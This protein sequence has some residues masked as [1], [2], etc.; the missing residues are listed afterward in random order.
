MERLE[1]ARSFDP[2]AD[3]ADP[4]RVDG[5]V[6]RVPATTGQRYF[7]LIRGVELVTDEHEAHVL[8][9]SDLTARGIGA[10]LAIN[11]GAVDDTFST[12]LAEQAHV[13]AHR[14]NDTTFPERPSMVGPVAPTPARASTDIPNDMLTVKGGTVNLQIMFRQR[15]C[16]MYDGAPF[17]NVR[18]PWHPDLHGVVTQQRTATFSTFAIGRREVT[19][20]QFYHFLRASAYQPRHREQFVKHWQN[21][22]PQRVW[23]TRRWEVPQARMQTLRVIHVEVGRNARVRIGILLVT[24][25]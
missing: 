16:G 21:G 8:L 15:E 18:R 13:H 25:A 7:D 12:F 4:A 22:Q 5:T 24:F 20:Q 23:S 10:Y 17:V 14:S 6:L 3:A 19:N 2:A 1:R 11:S 9:H